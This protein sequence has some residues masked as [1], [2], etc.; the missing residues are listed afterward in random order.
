MLA[1]LILAV[2]FLTRLPLGG[3]LLW[4]PQ[5]MA[6]APRWFA[7]VG[8][9]L[10]L[11]GAGLL[12]MLAQVLA[13]PVAVLLAMAALTAVTGALHEDGLADSIDALGGRDAARGLDIMR[14]S[15]IGSYG[16][17][18]LGFVL[19]LQAT[20][21]A[22][23]PLVWAC[24]ALIVSQC[25]GRAAMT[26]A[27]SQGRY[28]RAKGAGTGLDQPLGAAGLGVVLAATGAALALAGL[29]ALPPGA[30]AT[31]LAVGAGCGAI[32]RALCLRRNG[33]DTGDL[34]GALHMI[35]ATGTL[36]GVAAWA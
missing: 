13:Q 28:L 4:T 27:L 24:A 9:M 6:Q 36:L 15:R 31:A 35:T 2:E 21:L 26:L 19:A 22:L 30:L 25:A 3:H 29:I 33:G 23:L 12:W 32:W 18:G 20:A 8:L 17:L 14:D 5:A 7:A 10:G 1:P 16:V 34:L 11:A